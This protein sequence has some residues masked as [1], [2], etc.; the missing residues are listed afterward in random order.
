M[1]PHHKRLYPILQELINEVRIILEAQLVDWVVPA[2]ERNN[3]T[4]DTM[5]AMYTVKVKK[6]IPRPCDAESVRL[7]TVF[8]EERNVV[9]V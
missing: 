2:A 8:L 9:F 6:N 3:P 1:I 7:D 4:M 5:S